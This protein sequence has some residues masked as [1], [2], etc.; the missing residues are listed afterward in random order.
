MLELDMTRVAN[1]FFDNY[2]AVAK[3]RGY[4]PR[5]RCHGPRQICGTLDQAH[6]LAA[7]PARSFDKNWIFTIRRFTLPYRNHGNTS[8]LHDAL[9]FQLVAHSSNRLRKRTDEDHA[10][11]GARSGQRGLLRKKTGSRMYCVGGSIFRC[12]DHLVDV[13]IARDQVRF[14]RQTGMQCAFIGC[15]EDGCGFDTHF[16]QRVRNPDGNFAAVRDQNFQDHWINYLSRGACLKW[17]YLDSLSKTSY[18]LRPKKGGTS[19]L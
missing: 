6:S 11:L 10:G 16:A 2:A 8:L 1:V 3:R 14:P 15:S 4:F 7:A 17:S 12:P 5:S 13:E 18:R 9:G 19:L